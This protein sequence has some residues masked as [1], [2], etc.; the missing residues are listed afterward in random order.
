MRF[1]N[2]SVLRLTVFTFPLT[3]DL[4]NYTTLEEISLFHWEFG[5]IKLNP[6]IFNFLSDLLWIP[7]G[8]VLHGTSSGLPLKRE[9]VALCKILEGT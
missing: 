6:Y 7:F 2:H 1:P 3:K 4:N 8:L 9:S 5:C